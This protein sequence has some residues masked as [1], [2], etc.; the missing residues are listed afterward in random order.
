MLKV[1]HAT[2]MLLVSCCETICAGCRQHK[3]AAARKVAVSSAQPNPISV[4]IVHL[5]SHSKLSMTQLLQDGIA[6][7]NAFCHNSFWNNVI[8]SVFQ[9]QMQ[10]AV[11]ESEY[12]EERCQDCTKCALN[13]ERCSA[14]MST[15]SR[16]KIKMDT[17]YSNKS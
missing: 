16:S 9:Q 10:S 1:K 6:A 4:T 3:H 2:A 11:T 15:S 7:L 8:V 13:K 12:S 5:V 14:V 17:T